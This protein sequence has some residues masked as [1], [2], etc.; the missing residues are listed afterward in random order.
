M[1]P[2]A[3][4]YMFVLRSRSTTDALVTSLGRGASGIE[5]SWG[6]SDAELMAGE[7]CAEPKMYETNEWSSRPQTPC[8]PAGSSV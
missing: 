7:N 3:E 6:M 1:K 2:I 4:K 5:P 8:E